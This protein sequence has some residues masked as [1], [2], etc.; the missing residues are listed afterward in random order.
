MNRHRSPLPGGV[1]SSP[2]DRDPPP[3]PRA[4]IAS[5]S[6]DSSAEEFSSL[7][8]RHLAVEPSASYATFSTTPVNSADFP[9]TRPPGAAAAAVAAGDDQD[10]FGEDVVEED[11]QDGWVEATGVFD[12]EN[13][14]T[15]ITAK[16]NRNLWERF[17]RPFAN[18]QGGADVRWTMVFPPEKERLFRRIKRPTWRAEFAYVCAFWILCLTIISVSLGLLNSDSDVFTASFLGA[19]VIFACEILFTGFLLLL[20]G[21]DCKTNILNI[22]LAASIV[23]TAI[24]FRLAGGSTSIIFLVILVVYGGLTAMSPLMSVGMTTFMIAVFLAIEIACA[25]TDGYSGEETAAI[26]LDAFTFFTVDAFGIYYA[27]FLHYSIRHS[28][29]KTLAFARNERGKTFSS[30]KNTK[31]VSL[32]NSCFLSFFSS[33]FSLSF[34]HSHGFGGQ[35]VR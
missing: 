22:L 21:Q 23:L 27:Y 26:I 7:L 13:F 11:I 9:T 12:T 16:D 3:P 5:F 34:P 14:P 33:F 17:R 20:L 6:S 10:E 24:T 2:R 19:L 1:N 28:Y 30:L 35:K 31:G 29:L 32:P 4:S 25:H 8:P 15:D 18:V